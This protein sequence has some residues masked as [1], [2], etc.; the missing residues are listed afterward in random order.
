MLTYQLNLYQ[1][2]LIHCCGSGPGVSGTGG[3]SVS[4]Y[5]LVAANSSQLKLSVA[6]FAGGSKLKGLISLRMS[7]LSS[8]SDILSV[9]WSKP[10]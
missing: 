9:N 1:H 7:K 6:F 5:A 4:T 8:E 10:L 3:C 2:K